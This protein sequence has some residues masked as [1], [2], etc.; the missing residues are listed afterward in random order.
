MATGPWYS[1]H[2][3]FPKD[4]IPD[5]VTRTVRDLPQ[6]MQRAGEPHWPMTWVYFFASVV[7][8]KVEDF[9]APFAAHFSG[10][11][12]QYHIRLVHL[13]GGTS[14]AW[15][16]VLVSLLWSSASGCSSTNCLSTHCCCRSS[17][18][19]SR[20]RASS[21]RAPRLSSLHL[22]SAVAVIAVLGRG[23]VEDELA[24]DRLGLSSSGAAGFDPSLYAA[25]G[26]FW[27]APSRLH[28]RDD[29]RSLPD[30]AFQQTIR[31]Q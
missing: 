26:G 25:P 17:A 23:R 22:A 29:R 1:A 15:G 5:H 14:S 28:P 3:R 31:R 10:T 20:R 24:L 11:V 30:R 2:Q 19:A 21:S 18:I 27:L 13:L 9:L 6:V 8:S 4:G 12:L 16:F 7:Y